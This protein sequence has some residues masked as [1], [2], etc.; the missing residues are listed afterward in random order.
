MVPRDKYLS[1]AGFH[2]RDF[3]SKR[4]VALSA[5]SLGKATLQTSRIYIY[6]CP[7]EFERGKVKF[8]PFPSSWPSVV[9][10]S[11]MTSAHGQM[12]TGAQEVKV[13]EEGLLYPWP[14]LCCTPPDVLRCDIEKRNLQI[15]TRSS[16]HHL[17]CVTGT[18][19]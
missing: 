16:T 19:I 1:R 6:S 8:S 11:L 7:L 14:V 12:K 10:Q 15:S 13:T 17:L 4:N 9:A 18:E 2:S 5:F 3:T